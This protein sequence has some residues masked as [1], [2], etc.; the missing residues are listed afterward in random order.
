MLKVALILSSLT[1]CFCQTTVPPVE[2]PGDSASEKYADKTDLVESRAAAAVKVASKAN[3]DGKQEVVKNELRVAQAY[4]PVPSPKDVEFAAKRAETAKPKDYDEAVK[5]AL[6]QQAE[7]ERL[8][9]QVEV[10]R[11]KTA[12]ALTA[13]DEQIAALTAKVDKAEA[14]ALNKEYAQYAAGMIALGALLCLVSRMAGMSL[15]G[16]GALLFVLVKVS[17]NKHFD[18]AV[19]GI[20]LLMALIGGW[21]LWRKF[22]VKPEAK[23]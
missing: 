15:M 8:W 6:A 20:A 9:K 14:D 2:P 18:A 19:G 22:A 21:I 16:A 11:A 7:T 12:Q 3:E 23:E 17:G 10:D 13:K 5:F 4:L 1:L